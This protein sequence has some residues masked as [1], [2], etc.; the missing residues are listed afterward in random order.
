M[1]AAALGRAISRTTGVANACEAGRRGLEVMTVMAF[2]GG[3]VGW[4]L[5]GAARL[6]L[7]L[8][9]AQVDQLDQ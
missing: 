2:G 9:C 7:C 5:T 6:A 3:V 8:M 4:G 1:P